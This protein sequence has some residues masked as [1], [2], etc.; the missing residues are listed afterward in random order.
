MIRCSLQGVEVRQNSYID[1][2]SIQDEGAKNQHFSHEKN[3]NN[4]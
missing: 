1:V 3:K 2:K 4:L